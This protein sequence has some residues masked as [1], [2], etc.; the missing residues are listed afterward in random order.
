[1]AGRV[2]VVGGDMRQHRRRSAP[3]RPY[4]REVPALH[5]DADRSHPHDDSDHVEEG[6][7]DHEGLRFYTNRGSRKGR[8]LAANPYASAVFHWAPLS[9]QIRLAGPVRA[10]DDPESAAYWTT[11]PRASR[12]SA[13]ASEQGM[14]VASRAIL[15]HRSNSLVL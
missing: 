12:L 11:R 8:D 5:R 9:R 4:G 6:V 2:L 10:M 14:E 13:W 1:M 15:S 7:L 3:C